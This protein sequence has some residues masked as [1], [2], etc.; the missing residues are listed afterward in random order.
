MREGEWEGGRKAGR[1]QASKKERKVKKETVR[2]EGRQG[3]SSI[4]ARFSLLLFYLIT[5]LNTAQ[6]CKQ[7]SRTGLG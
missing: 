6:H 2:K 5:Q 4:H 7:A 3:L 1:N